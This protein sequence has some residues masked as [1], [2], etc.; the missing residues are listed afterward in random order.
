MIENSA[1]ADYD[2]VFNYI[3]SKKDVERLKKRFQKF[4]IK[5]VCLIVD[6]K[7]ILKRD[8][9][10]PEDCQMGERCLVLLKEIL[11]ENFAEKFLLDTSNLNEEQT[12]YEILSNDR[13]LI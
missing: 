13:F 9:L 10:R 4:G 12:F 1:K 11:D 6:E 2:V 5:F 7:T 3:L 8:K